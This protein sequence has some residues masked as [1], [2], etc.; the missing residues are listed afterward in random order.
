MPY[1]I[2]DSTSPIT[3]FVPPT[4]ER[5]AGLPEVV[6]NPAPQGL[7]VL[8]ADDSRIVTTVHSSILRNAGYEVVTAADG[9]EAM[10]AVY[11]ELPDVVLLDIFMPRMN[12]Y[13]V[14]RLIK[15]DSAV[16]HIPVLIN[17]ASEGRSAE[18]WSLHTGADGFMLKGIA[19]EELL[20]T[21]AHVTRK[22]TP[23]VPSATMSRE[24]PGP[25]EILSKVCALVDQELY[26]TTI[27]GMELQ[28]MLANMTEGILTV[29][30]EGRISSANHFL[31]DL[32]E[33]EETELQ[34]HQCGEA[35][36]NTIGDT[37]RQ[38][39]ALALDSEHAIVRE[40]EVTGSSGKITPV[41]ISAISV[42]DYL[43][44]VVGAVCVFQ[45]ITRR[46]EVEAL[47]RLKN[48][49]TDMIVH[50]LRT[51]L[52]SFL[53][54]MES[55]E[56]L[57]ELNADQR[58]LMNISIEG[59]QILLGMVNDLLD[60]SKM[61]NGSM[62][63]EPK[64]VEIADLTQRALRQVTALALAKG[65]ELICDNET[66]LLPLQADDEKLVR[67]MVNLLSNA[68][69]FTPARG[70]ITLSTRFVARPGRRDSIVFACQDTGEGI[71]TEAFTHIF[72]KF[73]QVESRTSGRK[74]STGL[75]LTFC[76]MA[77][78]AHGGRIWVQSTMGYGSTFLFAIPTS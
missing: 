27:K 61:E 74:M 38:I 30:Y 14:C 51:P 63:I 66:A 29:D 23:S 56:M 72:E 32:L 12:G 57:G 64:R 3:P 13:Q 53:T 28:T 68:I 33:T 10:Q 35:L 71:P 69:K 15:Q 20:D 2:S 17:T 60:I 34:G 52:T 26:A 58:E 67:V 50:D 11:R 7:K 44:D 39:I 9:I 47:N 41:E 21:I 19:P 75:G 48:D 16:S 8:I 22:P 65:L 5:D 54:G 6:S 40:G 78:E 31:C 73:G 43:G 45:D 59:G 55:V 37:T 25:E 49:L 70:S 24:A 42:K 46:R 36:G 18:F 1:P 76:K 62:K 77:V 4:H